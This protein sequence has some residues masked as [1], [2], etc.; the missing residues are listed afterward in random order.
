M[1]H[2]PFP[3][4]EAAQKAAES[5]T[6]PRL[7]SHVLS[8]LA[9]QQLLTGQ[10]NAALQT[11]ASISNGFERRVALLVADYQNFP[12]EKVE[13]L[14]QLMEKDPQT[15]LLAGRLALNMLDANNVATAWKLI[16]TAAEPF[17]SEQQQYDFLE[18][19]LPLL[20]AEGWNKIPRFFRSFIP[21]MYRDWASLAI[22]KYLAG[23]GRSEDAEEYADALSFPLRS[24]W[25]YWE[26]SR[27]SPAEQA[28]HYF[29]KAVEMTEGVEIVDN[30]DETMEILAIQLRIFGRIAF[31]KGDKNTGERLLERCEAAAAAMAMRMG[32]YRMQC[33][34]GKV[35][36]ELRLIT[37]IREYL[38]IDDIS[39]SLSSGSGRSQVLVWLAEA[40]WHEGWTQAV[41]ALS[42]PERGEVEEDRARQIATVLKRSVAHQ[43]DLEVSSDFSENAVRLSGEAFETFYFNPFA[44]A[45][46]GCY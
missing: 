39:Q 44:E 11:F 26:M 14:V 12:P 7:K 9:H 10:F 6:D 8:E 17:E 41:A 30:D 23:Q 18:N 19:V 2:P 27:L 22:I 24:S 32:R 16:E 25:A 20:P 15:E 3:P 5:L 40:G 33:F 13:P 31:E 28:K 37:S 42:T 36:V 45:D 34:L 4:F 35:L 21:G 46:C 29:D 38:P 43:Q 1:P